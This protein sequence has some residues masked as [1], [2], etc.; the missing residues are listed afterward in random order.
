MNF[1]ETGRQKRDTQGSWQWAKHVKPYFDHIGLK[2]EKLRKFWSFSR[3]D[4]NFRVYSILGRDT[5]AKEEEQ[6]ILKKKKKKINI[7]KK[8]EK[9]RG[10]GWGVL[11]L[12]HALTACSV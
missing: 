12:G 3:V 9:T 6:K 1:N 10:G 8:G 11:R 2:R 5:K 7:G 4:L